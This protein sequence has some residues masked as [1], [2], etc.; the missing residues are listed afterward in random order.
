[1]LVVALVRPVKSNPPDLHSAA[2]ATTLMVTQRS[3]QAWVQ[4]GREPVARLASF[5]FVS[6]EVDCRT[7]VVHRGPQFVSVS[8]SEWLLS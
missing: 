8:M 6:C 2:A 5:A 3:H 4:L 1:M 7:A